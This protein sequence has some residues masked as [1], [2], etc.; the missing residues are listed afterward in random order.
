MRVG[1]NEVDDFSHFGDV[2]VRLTRFA[3][4]IRN[5]AAFASLDDTRERIEAAGLELI[6]MVLADHHGWDRYVAP[7]WRAVSDWLRA[8]PDSADAAKLRQWIAEG[9]RNHLLYQRRYLGW[10]VFVTR[11]L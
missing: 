8:N 7:Q 1:Q 6:E 2:R 10:G 9:Q 3:C 5:R 4:P 11:L